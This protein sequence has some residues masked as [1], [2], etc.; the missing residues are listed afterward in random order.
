MGK[1]KKTNAMRILDR[2]KVKY[3]VYEY[4]LVNG[5]TDGLTVAKAVGMDP[6]IVFKTLV[7]LG[8]SKELYVF[9]IPVGKELDLKKAAKAA[10]EKKIEMLPQKDLLK[11][12]GYVHGGCSPL[13]MKKLYKTF[14]NESVLGNERLVCSGGRIGVQV[15]LLV[16][17]LTKIIDC[18]ISPLTK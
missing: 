10:G 13:G 4:E 15:D 16:E 14:I 1:S 11:Y 6:K 5:K 7:T 12:T 2:Y 9:I 8:T 17:D 3:K 18:E